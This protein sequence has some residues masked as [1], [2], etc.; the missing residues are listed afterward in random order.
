M[1]WVR[2]LFS[3]QR[4]Y[5]DL[6]VSIREHLEEKTEELME[7][8]LSREEAM[9]QARKHFGNVT[10]IEE[11][12]REAWQWPAIES[13]WA[14]VRSGLRQLRK[15]PG[16]AIT[17]V[18]TMALGIGANT[19][20]FTLVHAVLLKSLP[21]GDPQSLYRLGDKEEGSLTAGLQNENG[22]FDVFS[23]RLYR[24]LRESTPEFAE[25]AAMQ[26]GPN[27]IGVRR[28]SDIAVTRASEVVSG[29][30]FRTLGVGAF[31]GRTLTDDDDRL[32]APPA[33]VMSYQSWQT[34]YAAD[35]SV[36]GAT[37][38]LQSQPVRIVGIAAAGFYGD[39]LSIDPPA[40]WIPLAAEPLLLGA[41]STLEHADECWLYAIGR[42]RPGTAL[43]PLQE[44]ISANLRQWLLAQDAYTRYG[45]AKIAPKLHVVL[46]PAGTGIRDLQQQTSRELYLLLAISGFVL[47]VA[48]ANVANLLL[49]RGGK[50]R[51]EISMRIALG[52]ARR[53][54]IR[55][56]LTESALLGCLGGLAGLAVAYGG[57]RLLLALA[58]PGSPHAAIQ[59]GPSA[60]V[61]GFAFLL[62]LA[63]GVVF[64][65]APAWIISHGD[66]AEAL[67]SG[68]R[69][70]GDRTGTAQRRLIVVQTALSLALLAGAG[71]L[72]RSLVNLEQQDFGIETA[73]RYVMHL[74]PQAAGY[75]PEQLAALIRT[76]EQRFGA[77]PWVERVGVALYSPLDAQPWSFQVFI[78]GRPD[79]GH[80]T[81]EVLMD[82]VSPD[83]FG[84]VGQPV[85]RGRG[86][87]LHDAGGSPPVALVNRTFIRKYFPG[88]DPIGKRFGNYGQEDPAA[89]EIVGVVADAKYTDPR[90]PATPMFFR[91]ILQWQ[92]TL[93]DPTS[94]SIENLSHYFGAM[95]LSV[96]ATP[97]N[98]ENTVRRTLADVNPNLSVIDLHSFEFAV[99][100]NLNPER[101][102]ARLT[103]LFGLLTLAVAAVGLY[104][105][106]S[107]QV[108]QRAREIGLRMAFGAGRGRVVRLVLLGALM[109]VALG[110]AV[111]VPLVPIGAGFLRHTLY[112]V[113]PYDPVSLAAAGLVLSAAAAIAAF[114][115]ARRAAAIDPVRALGSE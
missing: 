54:L 88:E 51:T 23:Y 115:P 101:L 66:P 104:G 27:P 58:Y 85:I 10:L 12:S 21:V 1:R 15:A 105:A 17:V 103:A 44:K 114:I 68:A 38:Y 41:N 2:Q 13:V 75:G 42:V 65:M 4:R 77:I 106:T 67:R 24:H 8:G 50:R 49:A 34:A 72:T 55:Q 71:M 61:L 79:P 22:D 5:D 39:R 11:Q 40:F 99:A 14:D 87:T 91:P 94:I 110:L 52:A 92:E 43:V 48:C 111:G 19:A 7:E 26:I 95:V 86:F 109:P 73:N 84:A 108:S 78:P 81:Q 9:C 90:K 29:N 74:D 60:A 35:P 96:R 20:I 102:I 57:T 64:G 31:A 93:T 45:I 100:S 107:Y 16:F 98:L 36:I 70:A 56:M 32:G 76:L 97:Q 33:A 53:R 30:Y 28:G 46:T 63:T 47:L 37:F 3:R 59:T 6:S 82:R 18:L 112:L 80:S 113:Q 83:F 62:S 69:L 89:C 25:L